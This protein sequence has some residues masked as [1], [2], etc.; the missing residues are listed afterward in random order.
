MEAGYAD[1]DQI[2]TDP[3]LEL[4][5]QDPRFS[6]RSSQT[7]IGIRLGVGLSVAQTLCC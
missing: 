7:S 2:L 4:I 5:R 3:D 6:V 1:F